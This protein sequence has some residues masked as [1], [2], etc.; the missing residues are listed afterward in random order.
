MN[1]LICDLLSHKIPQRECL[2]HY[3]LYC[4]ITRNI[5]PQL[6]AADINSVTARL[7]NWSGFVAVARTVFRMMILEDICP[8]E[9]IVCHK[10]L[11]AIHTLWMSDHHTRGSGGSSPGPQSAQTWSQLSRKSTCLGRPILPDLYRLHWGERKAGDWLFSWMSDFAQGPDSV[12][13]N[14]SSQWWPSRWRS[15]MNPS[16]AAAARASGQSWETLL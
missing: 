12:G 8:L 15:L 10:L 5:S 1:L 2:T 3:L 9:T 14:P 11:K 7:H 6:K 16:V 13:V 4:L